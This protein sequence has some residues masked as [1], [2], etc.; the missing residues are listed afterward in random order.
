MTHCESFNTTKNVHYRVG[1]EVDICDRCYL[2]LLK[3]PVEP[4]EE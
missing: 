2:A 4:W 3:E 1:M